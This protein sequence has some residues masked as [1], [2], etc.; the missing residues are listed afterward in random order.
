MHRHD[1]IIIGGGISGASALH[2]LAS[3]GIDALLLEREEHLGGVIGSRRSDAGALMEAGPN[4]AQM[5]SG[6]LLDLIAELGLNDRIVRPAAVAASRYIMRGGRLV[7]LPMRPG[8][9]M[10]SPLFS[11]SARLRL[12]R[13]PFIGPAPADSGESVAQFVERR[14]G[15]EI[16]DYAVNPFV[17][18][19]YAGRPESLS[20]RHAFPLLYDLEQSAGSLFKGGLRKMR[21]AKKR[22]GGTEEKGSERRGGIFSFDEGMG[23]LPRA[24]EE[25]WR[26]HIRCGVAVER[27]ERRE[28]AWLVFASSGIFIADRL[29]LATEASVT[30][31]LLAHL[32]REA[33]TALR[34]IEYPPLAIAQSLYD[35]AAVAHPLDGFGLLIPE[36]EKRNVLGVIF[37]SS[38]FP[39]RAPDGTVLLTT[40]VGGARSPGLALRDHEEMMF[41]IHGELRR[42]LGISARPREFVLTIRQR[43][44]PQYNVGYGAVLDAAARAEERL[45]GLHLLGSYR[46]GVSVGDCVASAR[47]L[48][49]RLA[50]E[51]PRPAAAAGVGEPVDEHKTSEVQ[52]AEG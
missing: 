30:A 10:R 1:V 15:R 27:I 52:E 46:G 20:A 42:A 24:V 39:N 40:F 32:D 36:A 2:W 6:D 48:V 51:F 5:K 9:F 34:S 19:I 4:S 17:S 8:A 7:P 12:L 41:D 49:R 50:G 11:A 16:L 37:S 28:G 44:I 38:L 33:A 3:I 29:V 25:R 47:R 43:A 35:R 22:R 13:E 23:R 21:E 31:E 18:G 14:L 45:K 26:R